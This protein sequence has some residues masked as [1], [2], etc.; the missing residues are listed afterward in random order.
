MTRGSWPYLPEQCPA[1]FYFEEAAPPFVD[2]FGYEIRGFCR[3]PADRHGV[4]PAA[5]AR[6][7][8]GRS[9]PAVRTPVSRACRQR[10]AG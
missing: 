5:K 9:L 7:V 3:H 8:A 10:L 6:H 1:C 2:D 4:V